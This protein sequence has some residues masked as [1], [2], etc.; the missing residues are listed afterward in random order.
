MRRIMASLIHALPAMANAYVLLTLLTA[1]YAILGVNFFKNVS[2][3]RFGSFFRCACCVFRF[4]L[5][6]DARLVW[7]LILPPSFG[8]AVGLLSL[9]WVV[10]GC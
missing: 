5:F 8:R 9:L 1:I 3:E 4:F 10:R 6:V 2:E 7:G